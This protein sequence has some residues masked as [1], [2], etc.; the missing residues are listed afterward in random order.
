MAKCKLGHIGLHVSL[1]DCGGIRAT[2]NF[3]CQLV[4]L[5][6]AGDLT[7]TNNYAKNRAASN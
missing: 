5:P 1:V 4:Q 7:K 6:A 3:D 2:A